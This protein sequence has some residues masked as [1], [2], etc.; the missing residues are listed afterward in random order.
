MTIRFWIVVALIVYVV[1]GYWEVRI[2]ELR[3]RNTQLDYLNMELLL[4]IKRNN[5]E[6]HL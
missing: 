2:E 4:Q 3:E 5:E 1:Y 6:F